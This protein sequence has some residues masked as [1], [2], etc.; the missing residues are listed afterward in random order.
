MATLH[1]FAPGTIPVTSP[2][3]LACGP[4]ANPR[5]RQ[6]S[7]APTGSTAR[8]LSRLVTEAVPL[9]V[10]TGTTIQLSRSTLGVV[11]T[12]LLVV[13]GI[14]WLLT[15]A[16]ALWSF[17]RGSYV[18]WSSC[19]ARPFQT[20]CLFALNIV[21]CLPLLR[22]RSPG[23][24]WLMLLP[25]DVPAWVCGLGVTLAIVMMARPMR[26]TCGVATALALSPWRPTTQA[27]R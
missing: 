27:S 26:R 14:A 3:K 17:R 16:S 2:A 11:Q 12:W 4:E 20:V 15:A 6:T 24:T 10:V 18:P 22:L 19:T 7:S 21:P 25:P 13:F 5:G 9:F 23:T 1:Y 8:R